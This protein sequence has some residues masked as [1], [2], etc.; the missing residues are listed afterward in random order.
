VSSR[1]ANGSVWRQL[2]LLTVVIVS[3]LPVTETHAAPPQTDP[4]NVDVSKTGAPTSKYEFGMFIEHIGPLIY[5]SLWSE[6]LDDRK[7]YF[8][9]SSKAPEAQARQGG[10]FPGRQL[11]QWRPIGGDEAVLMDKEN[12]FVGDQSPRIQLDSS[13]PHGIEQ[14]GLALVKG[15]KY[16][17]RIY[18]RGTPRASVKVTLIWGDGARDRQTIS[19]PTASA[20]YKNSRLA[21]GAREA[22]AHHLGIGRP[23]H[24]VRAGSGAQR[25]DATRI[26]YRHSHER[27]G[28]D[29]RF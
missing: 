5:R 11:R 1:N 29:S 6:M 23:R 9:I 12:P 13:T 25:P 7:F 19:I 10:G 26:S 22:Q 20:T 8:P 24:Q 27:C 21:A 17:G 4:V 18:L 28:A 3:I 14:S 15:K 2:L 16:A